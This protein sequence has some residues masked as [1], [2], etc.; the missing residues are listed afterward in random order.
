MDVDEKMFLERQWQL[1]DGNKKLRTHIPTVTS[2]LNIVIGSFYFKSIVELQNSSWLFALI[3][4]LISAFGLWALNTIQKQYNYS[5]S[6]IGY[7]YDKFE[8][9]YLSEFEYKLDGKE[10]GEKH[11]SGT[12]LFIIGY[13]SISLIGCLLFFGI[14]FSN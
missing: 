7:L 4:L 1:L 14:L 2:S 9:N 12:P 6:K 10:H 13:V 5:N 11:E 3:V 8:T